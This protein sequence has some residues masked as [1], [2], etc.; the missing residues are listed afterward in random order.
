M[1]RLIN[2]F[3]N[4]SLVLLFVYLIIVI[5]LYTFKNKINNKVSRIIL[6]CPLFMAIVH[7]IY[8]YVPSDFQF[9]IFLIVYIYPIL[10]IKKCVY[11]VAVSLF[12][13]TF[14]ALLHN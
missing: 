7:Y 6:L 12:L 14:A 9:N 10:I 13:C 1:Y 8:Y 5:V 4:I 3:F 11:V 2:H